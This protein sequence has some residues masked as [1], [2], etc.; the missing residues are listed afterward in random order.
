MEYIN[1]VSEA[2]V[3]FQKQ[4]VAIEKLKKENVPILEWHIYRKAGLRSTV[5]NEVKRL[6]TLRMTEYETINHKKGF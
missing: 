4:R 2:I 1:N 6:I 5:S 3:A